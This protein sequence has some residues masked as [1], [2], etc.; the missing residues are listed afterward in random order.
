VRVCGLCGSMCVCVVCVVGMCVCVV[1]VVGM[2]V[3]VWSVW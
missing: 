1:H 2:C 3:R